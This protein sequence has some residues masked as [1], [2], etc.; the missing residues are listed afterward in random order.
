VI[1]RPIVLAG[2]VSACTIGAAYALSTK[3]SA[4]IGTFTGI[5]S[6]SFKLPDGVTTNVLFVRSNDTNFIQSIAKV[7]PSFP[8]GYC[9][10]GAPS[11][12]DV[13]VAN[14]FEVEYAYDPTASEG[15]GHVWV[16][17]RNP[18]DSKW[19]AVDSYYGPVLD[20]PTW[21]AAPYVFSDYSKLNDLMPG[22]LV[23]S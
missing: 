18:A 10:E 6:P 8:Q 9:Y 13:L 17:A 19:V 5:G 14:G 15:R 11:V 4:P 7:V 1:G 12:G 3:K 23:T 21:Y 20:D 22:Y 16:M 2:I